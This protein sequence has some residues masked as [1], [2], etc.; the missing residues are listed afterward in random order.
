MTKVIIFVV[1]AKAP[2]RTLI[3]VLMDYFVNLV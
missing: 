2:F 1:S 3:Q